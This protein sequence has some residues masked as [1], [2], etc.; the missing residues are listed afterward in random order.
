MLAKCDIQISKDGRKWKKAETIMLGNL[1][2]DTT[3]RFQYFKQ[4]VKA[5]YVRIETTEIAAG[6]KTVTIAEIDLF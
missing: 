4:A 6:G 2:K 5:R 1:I 3:K